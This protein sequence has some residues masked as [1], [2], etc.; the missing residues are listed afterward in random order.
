MSSSGIT[1]RIDEL[2]RIVIPKEIRNTLGI[3]DGELLEI[4]INNDE[5]IIKKFSQVKNIKDISL[6]ICDIISDTCNIDILITDRERVIVT[7]NNLQ[8]VINKELTNELKNLIDER[9]NYESKNKE[10]KFNIEK[11]FTIIPIIT[12]T[13][14]SGLV[15]VVTNNKNS[16]NMIYAKIIQKLIVDQLDIS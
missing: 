12:S 6:K 14:C 5:I 10:I 7:T 3:R 2:G 11:Y 16:E 9:Y 1:R 8:N 4:Y 15:I 13:D